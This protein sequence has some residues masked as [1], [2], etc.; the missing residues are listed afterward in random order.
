[1]AHPDEVIVPVDPAPA[2]R[3]LGELAPAQGAPDGGAPDEGAPDEGAPAERAPAE[4]APAER[5]PDEGAPAGLAALVARAAEQGGG[6]APVDLWDP[7]DCGAIAMRIAA[8]G[9]WFYGGTPILRERL[10]RLFARVLRRETDGSFALVT[11]AEKVTIAVDDVPFQ[12]V[13]LA[14]TGEGPRAAVTVR[15]NVGDVVMAGRDHPLR[16]APGEGFVPYVTVRR[17]LEARFTRAAAL[18]LAGHVADDGEG[19]VGIW[20]GGKFFRCGPAPIE[21]SAS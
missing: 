17:G 4:I 2:E 12:A 13:E 15:T 10:V 6:A 20:S 19:G 1:M 8:D 18:E 9:T 7:P 3:A 14:A 5:A 21:N 16:F 11:P